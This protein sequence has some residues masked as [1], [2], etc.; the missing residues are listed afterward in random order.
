VAIPAGV[1]ADVVDRRRL[2][3]LSQSISMVFA[4]VLGV[5]A[6]TDRLDVPL[7]LGGTF[8][9]SIALTMSAPAF[10]ALLPDLVAPSELTQ[11]IGMNNIAYNGAQSAG[12]AL[13]GVVIALSGPGAV[14]MLNAASFLGIVAV[15][16]RYRPARPGPTSDEPLMAAMKSGAAYFLRRPEL[17]KYAVRIF[18]AFLAIAALVALLPV[19]ARQ[20]LD[21]TAGQYGVMAAALG[22]GA[23]VAVWLVPRARAHTGP[24]G[25][26]VAAAITWSIG[27]TLLAATT[28]FPVAV[29]GVLLAGIG[30]MVQM[31]I[32]YSMF[33]LL[34]PAWIRGRASSVVML[35]V[36][37]AQSVGT[38]A[39]GAIADATGVA[40]ALFAAAAFHVVATIAA[41]GWFR[42]VD[43]ARGIADDEAAPV[44]SDG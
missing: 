22:V 33:M 31:N 37:L 2:I 44:P 15:M 38:V 32:V 20:R 16:W 9:L 41:T 13:A 30:S 23:V 40:T 6:I 24:N 35:T 27:I 11:A 10:M 39:W 17:Q 4:A 14:F 21:T 3:L 25:L 36:W 42:L 12:P 1:L 18:L 5:L 28:S 34:L 8:L 43:P 26:V 29:V 19:V 7:L